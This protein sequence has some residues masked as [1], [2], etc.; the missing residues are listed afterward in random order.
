MERNAEDLTT[1]RLTETTLRGVADKTD[2]IVFVYY[3]PNSAQIT[4][5]STAKA[6]KWGYE[7][8][9]YFRGG[10]PAWKAAGYPI[11]TGE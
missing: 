2:E 6:I 8:V 1:R 5:W 9:H 11:E 10:A 4:R 7:K 3:L